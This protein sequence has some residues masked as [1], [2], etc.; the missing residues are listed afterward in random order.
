MPFE[1]SFNSLLGELIQVNSKISLDFD[2]IMQGLT[3]EIILEKKQAENR[4]FCE[5]YLK[6]YTRILG[7]LKQLLPECREFY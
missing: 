5:K 7:A 6:R 2:F 1:E 4:I 3:K